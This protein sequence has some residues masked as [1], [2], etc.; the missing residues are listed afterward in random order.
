MRDSVPLGYL[1]GLSELAGTSF[2][3]SREATNAVL[4]LLADQLGMRSGFLTRITP[5]DNRNE[6]LAAYNAPGGCDIPAG[7]L[8]PLSQTY[9]SAISDSIDLA[10]VLIEDTRADPTYRIHP[11]AMASPHIGSFIG[12]PVQL[13]DGSLYGTLCAVDPEPRMLTMHQSDLLVVLARLVATQ[14]ERDEDL[15]ERERAERQVRFQAQLLE[16]VPAAVIATDLEGRVTHWNRYAEQLYGW[17]HEEVLGENI[18]KLTVGPAEAEIAAEIMARLRAGRSWEGEFLATR[19][20]G[21]TF[22]AYVID[23]LACDADGHPVGIV[24]VSVDI[25]ERARLLARER[26]AR[27][28]AEDALRIRDEFLSIASHE[29]RNPVAAAKGSAQLLLRSLRRGT[30]DPGRTERGLGAVVAATDRLAVLIDDLLDVSRL[31]SGQFPMRPRPTDLAALVREAVASA[32]AAGEGHRLNTEGTGAPCVVT[33]DP[34]RIRQVVGNLLDNA[35]KYSPAG[36]EVCVLLS[37]AP[38]GA[39]LRVVDRGIGLPPGTEDR[40]F[41]P[42]GRAANAAASNLPGM[43]LGLYI[44]RRIAEAHGGSLRAESPGEGMGTT[45]TLRLPHQTERDVDGA[46]DGRRDSGLEGDLRG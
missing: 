27:S 1:G 11:A 28:E 37:C 22:P 16:Q 20:D 40:I 36:G 24:G 18:G 31:R 17:S 10:P 46:P 45:M 2:G 23:S 15:A 8:L 14:I 29:L 19:R 6:V 32:S 13:S 4:R 38:E 30:D 26:V 25:T 3:S 34:D 5:Q 7:A 9:C 44:C 41:E 35:V 39:T 21:S 12:V 42:F 33:I 43:G